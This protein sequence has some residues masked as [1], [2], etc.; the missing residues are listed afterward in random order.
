MRSST[1]GARHH[2]GLTT[3]WRDYESNERGRC[4]AEAMA[5]PFVRHCFNFDLEHLHKADA[6]V[7]VAKP[8][9]IGG[10]SAACELTWARCNHKR[11]FILLDNDPERWE[12]MALL[13]VDPDD[14][15]YSTAL[16]DR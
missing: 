14:I 7:L 2:P 4:Y 11:T 3:V 8:G 12:M 13:C 6:V 16:L 10:F 5:A 9:K 1:T 15:V